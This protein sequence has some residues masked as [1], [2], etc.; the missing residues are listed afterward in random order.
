MTGSGRQPV[1]ALLAVAAACAL[2]LSA[3][4]LPLFG[5]AAPA[6]EVAREIGALAGSE[7]ASGAGG[8]QSAASQPG[9]GGSSGGGS[10]GGSGG[11]GGESAGGGLG[12]LGL[13]QSGLL[14]GDGAGTVFEA[15]SGL[16]GGSGGSGGSGGGGGGGGGGSGG[17]AGVG[18]GG[19]GGGGGAPGV[20]AG[21]GGSGG[22]LLETFAG[23]FGGGGGG[24]G[25]GAGSGAGGGSGGGSGGGDGTQSGQAASIEQAGGQC[26]MA[27]PYEVCFPGRLTPGEETDVLV[28]RDGE[29]APGVT[30]TFNGEA[31]GRSD[32]EGT[33]T[34]RV[35]Y[36]RQ[37]SV[38]VS[39]PANAVRPSSD[40]QYSLARQT[41][42]ASVPVDAELRVEVAGEPAPGEG[43]TVSVRLDGRPV[44]DARVAI[45][46]ETVGRTDGQGRLA[47]TF[48]VAESATVRAERGEF[49]AERTVTLAD[50]DVSLATGAV[51]VG[52][53]G[54]SATVNV[55][56]GGSPVANATVAVGGSPVGRTATDGTVATTLPFAPTVDVRVTTPGG[57]TV[58]R[59]KAIF[60]LPLVAL[61][62]L[63]GLVGGVGYLVRQSEGTGRGLLEQLRV[64][65]ANLAADLLSALVGLASGIEEAAAALGEQVRAAIAAVSDADIDLG[66]FLRERLSAFRAALLGLLAAPADRVRGLRASLGSDGG[67]AAADAATT[68]TAT[69]ATA[70]ER[71]EAAWRRF[72]GRLGIRRTRTTTPGQV[73]GRGIAEG[74]P[75]ESVRDLTDAFRTVEYSDA[76]PEDHVGTAERAAADLGLDEDGAGGDGTEGGDADDGTDSDGGAGGAD[77]K[78]RTDGGPRSERGGEDR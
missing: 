77:G 37:L 25:A 58:T 53:P 47:V 65:L 54:Q 17:G 64:T 35:P 14:S 73:A 13:G 34:A 31:V 38:G 16:A 55:T 49:S 32:T 8:S 60:V 78:P 26:V 69:E 43:A 71:I 44:P 10:G 1:R 22:G 9:G 15:L 11:S 40:L 48:P 4:V 51:P 33:L 30:V 50:I 20:P 52:L 3:T 19:G 24:G 70:R 18:G 23:L 45:D 41:G 66:T 6:G 12:D 75:A 27:A 74:H 59:S 21:G 62:A 36:V 42:G 72:V 28:L 46:G 5:A 67:S 56:D 57:L 61:L 29:P 7:R 76:D 39:A 68:G 63:L 2:I